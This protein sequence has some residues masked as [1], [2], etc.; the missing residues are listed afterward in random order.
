MRQSIQM[1]AAGCGVIASL[2]IAVPAFSGDEEDRVKD[3]E[4]SL[5]RIKDKLDGVASK[6]S[7]S[8]IEEATREAYRVKEAADKLKS[9][10][11]QNDPG[12]T[13]AASYADYVDKFQESMQVGSRT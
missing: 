4:N 5:S 12:K 9:M 10:N 11:A 2:A 13:M 6:S 1:M 8:D 3:I 7:S